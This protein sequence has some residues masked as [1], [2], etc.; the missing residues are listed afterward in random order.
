MDKWSKDQKRARDNEASRTGSLSE[1]EEA[2]FRRFRDRR[3][4]SEADAEAERMEE[5]KL[6]RQRAEREAAEAKRAQR[7]EQL[8]AN[9]DAVIERLDGSSCARKDVAKK[10]QK[11]VA[12]APQH[13]YFER[14]GLGIELIETLAELGVAMYQR[15][16]QPGYGQVPL[17]QRIEH[18]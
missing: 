11:L 2:Q 15:A 1:F 10:L 16:A 7:I 5:R 4:I 3:G 12:L 9:V 18:R 14:D 6:E 13:S 8:Q 17:R